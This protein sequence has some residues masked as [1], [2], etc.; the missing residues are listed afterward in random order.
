MSCSI[1]TLPMGHRSRGPRKL[2]IPGISAERVVTQGNEEKLQSKGMV[3]S[4]GYGTQQSRSAGSVPSVFSTDTARREFEL[5]VTSLGRNSH[6]NRVIIAYREALDD[7]DLK[8][9]GSMYKATIVALSGR[10]RWQEALSVMRDMQT[11][12]LDPDLGAF[13]HV[14]RACID[15][16]QV[17]QAFSLFEEM[18]ARRVAPNAT[19]YHHL[20]KGCRDGMWEKALNLLAAMEESGL[21]IS[22][23]HLN[24][25]IAA[26]GSSG[27]LERALD[28]LQEM[29][30]RGVA[31]TH[32]TYREVI[33]ACE[34][35]GQWERAL[36][37]L[38]RMEHDNLVPNDYCYN[39]AI[40]G[41][42]ICST[43]R[44][45]HS[46]ADKVPWVTFCVV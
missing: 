25:V 19:T 34:K 4:N 20:L 10:S 7:P 9:S 37:L 32:G 18:K 1:F 30:T 31:P 35:G 22:A 40:A 29:R 44:L 12:G 15:S 41:E 21:N 3:Q 14:I 46:C 38:E 26:C 24:S 43:R 13:N 28:T 5:L 33:L 45:F 8:L 16:S 39:A 17:E 23:K 36:S 11:A 6:W 2:Y 27:E 42:L